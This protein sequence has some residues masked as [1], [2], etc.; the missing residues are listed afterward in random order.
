M[1]G[2]KATVPM[3]RQHHFTYNRRF[4]RERERESA[5]LSVPAEKSVAL[6]KFQLIDFLV[7]AGYKTI[8]K[9]TMNHLPN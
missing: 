6:Y 8:R 5:V 2:M 1:F 4:T 7:E 9:L 3:Y